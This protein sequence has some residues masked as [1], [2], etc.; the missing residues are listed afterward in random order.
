MICDTKT[1]LDISKVLVESENKPPSFS[2]S[3]IP[4]VSL[5]TKNTVPEDLANDVLTAE[6]EERGNCLLHMIN[7]TE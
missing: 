2:E 3:S 4:L 5:A 7:V 1:R 6:D